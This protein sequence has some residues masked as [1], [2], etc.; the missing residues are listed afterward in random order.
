ML[1]LRKFQRRFI[2]NA[3]AD[4]I[5]L[6]CLTLPRGNG[7]TSLA[8]HLITRAMTPGDE[9]HVPG[10]EVL[11]GAASIEQARLTFRF[12]R[13]DLEPTGHYRFIDSVTRLGITDKRDG[14]RLRVISSSAKR[15]MGVVGVPLW[16]MDEPGSYETVGGQLMYDA[17]ATA[18][19]KPGSPLRLIFI[20]TLAPALTGWW[21]QLI[22]GGTQGN[23]YVQ[24]L[25]GDPA[26]WDKWS[27]IRRCNPLTAI[28][29]DFRKKLLSERDA[30]RRDVR[31]KARFL[32]YRL[33]VPSPD[34]STVLLTVEDWKRVLSRPVAERT[35]QPAVAIDLGAGRAWSAAVAIWETGRVEAVA[36][37]PGIPSIEEQEKRDRVPRGTYQKLLENGSLRMAHGR[38]VQ[39]V[40]DLIGFVRERW[41][42]P[43]H[44]ISD[45]FRVPELLDSVNGVPVTARMTRW[46]ESGFDIRAL[47]KMALDGPLNVSPD[48]AGILTASMAAAQVKPDDSG[49]VRLV[50]HGTNNCGRD[51]VAAAAVLACGL[52]ER[53]M[54]MR[55]RWRYRGAA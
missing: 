22:E 45:R 54:P 5:D 29:A 2:K 10:C 19:G 15:A 34:A 35:G 41:G 17:A 40:K 52:F 32:S 6:A 27:E 48:S 23:T 4:G 3:I 9:L 16:I 36:V 28:S 37:A 14:T 30:A 8:A 11:L 49:N 39:P 1:D 18:Q 53:S 7:K 13:S 33:N 50:K 47:R 21:H 26:K 38:R 25:Q 55:P 12:V 44:Y 46:S 42:N 20:G 43:S 31:L 24:T 51:D